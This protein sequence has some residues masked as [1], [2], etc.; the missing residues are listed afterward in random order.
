LIALVLCPIEVALVMIL[1][2]DLAVVERAI[3][4]VVLKGPAI[5]DRRP[6]LTFAIG[7]RA[8]A[9]EVLQHQD[10]VPI[11]GLASNRT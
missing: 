2:Q 5:D 4:A 3:V 9:K 8:G 10:L 1:Q 6:A 7:A 11:K